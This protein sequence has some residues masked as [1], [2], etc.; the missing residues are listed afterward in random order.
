MSINL[1]WRP[2]PVLTADS[3]PT[4]LKW[5]IQKKYSLPRVFDHSDQPYL[6]GLMDAGID[7]AKELYIAIETHGKIELYLE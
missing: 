7:G 6:E 3:L 4:G 2:V 1:F 5:I